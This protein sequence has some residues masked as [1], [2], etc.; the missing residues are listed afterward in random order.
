MQIVG[1]DL[2]LSG[3][4]LTS[5][6]CTSNGDAC[7]GHCTVPHIRTPSERGAGTNQLHLIHLQAVRHR[8]QRVCIVSSDALLLPFARIGVSM[9]DADLVP[10]RAQDALT[11]TLLRISLSVAA[12]PCSGRLLM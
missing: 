6:V 4:T 8:F 11:P 10:V 7:H 3:T 9:V 1:F 2:R 12:A 5:P